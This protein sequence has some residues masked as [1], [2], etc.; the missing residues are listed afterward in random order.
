MQHYTRYWGLYVNFINMI[1]EFS[2]AKTHLLWMIPCVCFLI[3]C[4]TRRF[5]YS[6]SAHNVPVLT[7]KGDSKLGIVYSTNMVSTK[8][9]GNDV[10]EGKGNG[11]DA[12]G[13]YAVSRHF[14]VQASFF[15]RREMNGGDS[16]GSADSS[17]LRYKRNL[18]EIGAGY[19]TKLTNEKNSGLFFQ[20]FAGAGL[21]KFSFTD[22]TRT[23][24]G[25][26]V[27]N[28]HQA[29]ITKIYFQPALLFQH[30]DKLGIG[31][32][33]RFSVI[34]Y[35]NIKTD[36]TKDELLI[37]NLEELRPRPLVYWEPSFVNAF[38]LGSLPVRLEMQVGLSILISGRMVNHRGRNFSL[39]LQSDIARL[40]KKKA[41]A[42][43][44]D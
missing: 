32:S 4:S 16:P 11:I 44:K 7:D 25:N 37:Y 22:H 10:F 36:Y 35:R 19:F 30:T 42:A 33:S 12:Q 20:F 13:A 43:Q 24:N 39:G 6:P 26:R 23:S 21:G 17:V 5:A 1:A 34:S 40:F 15:S 41:P 29:D 28:F 27:Q 3:S 18:T 31:L 38:S 2:R 14:A 9:I 8:T